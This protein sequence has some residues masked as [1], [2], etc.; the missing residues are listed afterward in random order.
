MRVCKLTG[1]SP[2]ARVVRE[3]HYSAKEMSGTH[4]EHATYALCAN[5][6]T[7]EIVTN[8]LFRVIAATGKLMT[9]G[10]ATRL[11]F[12]PDITRNKL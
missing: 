1:L 12:K 10:E 11:S 8:V 3:M 7:P 9:A 5:G 2:R 6:E 4:C